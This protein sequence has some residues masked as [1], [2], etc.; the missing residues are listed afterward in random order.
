MQYD[1][2]PQY[3]PKGA[4]AHLAAEVKKVVSIPVIAN[5]KLS[6]PDVAEGLLAAGKADFISIGRGLLADP[7]LPNKIR[8]GKAD[9]VRKCISCNIGCLG[10]L[11]LSPIRP[12]R[13]T[14]N[15]ML[16]LEE[17]YKDITPAT[18]RKKTVIVGAG[19]GGMAAALAAA[20]R[21]HE[22]VLFEKSDRFGGGG[23]FNLACIP[24]FKEE[25][26]YI[27]EYYEHA[28]KEYSNFKCFFK[29]VAT[30]EQI[31]LEKPDAVIIATGSTAM[32]PQIPGSQNGNASTYE[33][34][35]WQEKLVG[36]SVVIIGGGE[37][38]CE[39]ALYLLKK[40]IRVTILEMLSRVVPKMNAAT[41][42]CLV[43]ELTDGGAAMLTDTLVSAIEPGK[44]TYIKDGKEESA[45][46]ET[47]V[48]AVGA[49]PLN[50]LYLE[51]QNKVFELYIIGDA[52]A[53]RDIMHA[54]RE[55]FFTAY[56]I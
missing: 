45:E 37:V 12:F 43:K 7:D 53:P 1:C 35:L 6:D 54:V 34:V 26:L 28:L 50:G 23:Q 15:P 10:N 18:T 4:V 38:G 11:M 46:A 56:Y 51:L 55:G 40:G 9:S 42:N 13:C 22:V 16:G 25:L 17:K 29:T 48:M 30:A 19:P 36:A 3:L 47:V 31:L 33:D 41:R 20:Q 14:V 24:P 39:T 49:K 27:P 52:R 32:I 44:V 2:I 21:G 8:G 5:G